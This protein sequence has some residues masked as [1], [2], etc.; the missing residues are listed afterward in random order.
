[1]IKI[2]YITKLYFYLIVNLKK[3]SFNF[4]FQYLI[5]IKQTKIGEE[6][7]LSFDF[8]LHLLTLTKNS[9]FRKH[10]SKQ[11]EDIITKIAG[12]IKF[13]NKHVYNV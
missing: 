1:M 11:N 6:R 8:S 7:V 12:H 5:L 13:N 2:L 10:Y 3:V 9:K 4:N